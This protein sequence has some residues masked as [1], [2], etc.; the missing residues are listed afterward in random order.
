MSQLNHEQSDWFTLA[1][2]SRLHGYFEYVMSGDMVFGGEWIDMLSSLACLISCSLLICSSAV[3][4]RALLFV[5]QNCIRDRCGSTREKEAAKLNKDAKYG[6]KDG[7][8]TVSDV[9]EAAALPTAPPLAAPQARGSIG[10]CGLC[11]CFYNRLI[12]S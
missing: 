3:G 6:L 8:D 10:L 7:A 11:D 1:W 9:S 4:Q 5:C 12:G 2:G